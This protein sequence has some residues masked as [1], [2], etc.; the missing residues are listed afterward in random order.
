MQVIA[1][2]TGG[3]ACALQRSLRMSNQSFAVH[4]RVSVRS[5]AGWHRKPHTIL[6]HDTQKILD[7]ISRIPHA[8]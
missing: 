2:W 4:L 5:V 6:A 3:H 8:G 1:S 7:A